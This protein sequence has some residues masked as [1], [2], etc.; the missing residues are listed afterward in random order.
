MPASPGADFAGCR[1]LVGH[2][3]LIGCADSVVRVSAA[4]IVSLHRVAIRADMPSCP[5]HSIALKIV[6]SPYNP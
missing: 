5:G 4:A 3:G 1:E 2:L 6:S